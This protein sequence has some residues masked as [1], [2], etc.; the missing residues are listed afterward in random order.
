MCVWK[1]SGLLLLGFVLRSPMDPGWLPVF[2]HFFHFLIGL[3]SIS[4]I[5][6]LLDRGWLTEVSTASLEQLPSSSILFGFASCVWG[7][8]ICRE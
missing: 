7:G 8:V 2:L 4:S 5:E 1:E 3:G 6:F